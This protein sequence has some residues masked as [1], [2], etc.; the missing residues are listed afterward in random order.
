MDEFL[1][2]LVPLDYLLL[3]IWR[4]KTCNAQKM[5]RSRILFLKVQIFG[6]VEGVKMHQKRRLGPVGVKSHFQH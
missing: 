6:Q 4:K 3:E 5:L 1:D 2:T